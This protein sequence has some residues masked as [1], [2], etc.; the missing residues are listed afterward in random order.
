NNF[1]K[2]SI[3]AELAEQQRHRYQKPV[4]FDLAELITN[5]PQ[6]DDIFSDIDLNDVRTNPSKMRDILQYFQRYPRHLI[7]LIQSNNPNPF[8]KQDLFALI[9]GQASPVT[10]NDQIKR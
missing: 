5:K 9:N 6:N 1:A 3:A 7:Q 2:Q 10:Y 4:S 8:E